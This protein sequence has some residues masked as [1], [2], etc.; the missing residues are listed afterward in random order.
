[1]ADMRDDA[2][3]FQ[4]P[5]E[6]TSGLRRFAIVSRHPE[7]DVITS[8]VLR[9]IDGNALAPHK[10]G[11]HLTMFPEIP[12][13]G[14]VKHNYTISA[15][16][17][18]ATY[19]ISVKREPEGLVSRWLHDVATVGT[20]LDIAP[21]SGAFVLPEPASRPIVMLSG[22]VGL[23]PMVAMLEAIVARGIDVPVQFIHCTHD[24]GTHAFRDHVREL[25]AAAKGKVEVIIFYSR[26]RAKDVAG[27][28]FDAAGRVDMDWLI[29]HTPIAK[30]DYFVC[31]PL[32]FLRAFVP[33]LAKAGV[34]AERL[35]FEFFG[36]VEDLF[37]EDAGM[38][39]S[40]T[41]SPQPTVDGSHLA[42]AG[43]GFSRE[44]IGDGILDSAAEAV[45]ASSRDGLIVLWNSGAERVFGFSEAEALGQSLD[46]IIPEP[47]RA[48]HWEGYDETVASGRS[49]YGAGD[50]LAVPGLTK[51][52][53]RISLEFTI[54]LLKEGGDGP[55]QGMVAVIRD[56]TKRF[57]EMKALK[58]QLAAQQGA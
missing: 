35:H 18:G 48:R 17:N 34:G 54:A 30:A 42:R 8:F 12:G 23:T 40:T 52:G 7:S 53:R 36:P 14:M 56:V 51:D 41:P 44:Q 16:P 43:D 2:G 29:A 27:R 25:A 57:E 20:E 32:G 11:Q 55:V 10:P 58:K 9:P 39:Q 3:T 5:A 1:M 15:A 22:G 45:I 46:I 13:A 4:P 31:G 21:A 49:R 6:A 33:G 19:R 24:G 28:D 37:D 26:P 38:A 50:L 47:F